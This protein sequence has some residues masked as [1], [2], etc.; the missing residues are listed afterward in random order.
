M[1]ESTLNTVT[2]H[3]QKTLWL[4]QHIVFFSRTVV[5]WNMSHHIEY[6]FFF[7]LQYLLNVSLNRTPRELLS[8]Q[9]VS[10]ICSRGHSHLW[11]HMK[12]SEWDWRRTEKHPSMS[13][14]QFPF[15]H[16]PVEAMSQRHLISC[17]LLVRWPIYHRLWCFNCFNG[18]NGG[19]HIRSKQLITGY[20]LSD[21][22]NILAGD[23]V[24]DRLTACIS[25]L[26]VN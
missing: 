7:F 13:A 19:D 10:S 22:F 17:A 11:T 8:E 24:Y 15:A 5:L 18:S 25:S 12:D 14:Q 26:S 20:C 1:F 23:V 3:W 21:A 9:R 16:A 4:L 2:K 6:V